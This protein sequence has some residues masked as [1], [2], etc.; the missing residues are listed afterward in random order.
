MPQR[1]V[2]KSHIFLSIYTEPSHYVFLIPLTPTDRTLNLGYLLLACSLFRIF[3]GYFLF[4]E[5]Q[6]REL[7]IKL[8]LH[9]IT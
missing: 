1:Y 9:G 7:L 2:Q 4:H 5:L 3:A 6:S 8:I